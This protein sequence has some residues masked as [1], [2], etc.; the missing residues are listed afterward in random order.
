MRG[1]PMSDFSTVRRKMV[2]G[3]V[4]P[5]D[6]TDLRIIDAM[7]EVPREE[8]VPENL[9][10]L[11]Y[12]DLDLNVGTAGTKRLLLKP[13]VIAKMLQAA[14]IRNI[15]SVL[16]VGCATGYS[17]A[18]IAKLAGRVVALEQDRTLAAKAVEILAKN[19]IDNVSVKVATINEGDS[20][21][22]PYDVIVLD[23]ATEVTPK[24]LYQQMEPGGRLVGVF[25]M[26]NP[27]RAV[28]VTRSPADF[29][30]RAL[31]D[32]SA[33]ILPGFERLPVFVF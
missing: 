22:G 3:Q 19:Q 12:M 4:R 7:L 26:S 30:V 8:F 23:G 15:D 28:M 2:D 18:V 1:F 14:G 10:S 11:A 9:R 29:G 6:V 25:A 31:F 17:A 21:D 13:V 33:G 32:A 27:Q 20:A 5:S 16:V 24:E